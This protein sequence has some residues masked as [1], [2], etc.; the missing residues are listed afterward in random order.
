MAHAL[1]LMKE[2]SIH[3]IWQW[4]MPAEVQIAILVHTLLQAVYL[5]GALGLCCVQWPRTASAATH[6]AQGPLLCNLCKHEVHLNICWKL[7]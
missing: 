6:A 7:P 4:H 1:H 3:I 5:E 2:C